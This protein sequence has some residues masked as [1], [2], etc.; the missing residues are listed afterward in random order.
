MWNAQ[1]IGPENDPK[2]EFGA[3]LLRCRFDGGSKPVRIRVSADQ[4]YKL[5]LNGVQIGFGPQRG[6]LDHWFYETYNLAARPGENVLE[7]VVWSFGRLAPMAQHFA[8][9]GF[10]CEALDPDHRTL[11]TPGGWEIAR[12]EEIGFAMMHAGVGEFYI[13]VGPGEIHGPESERVWRKPHGIS[14]AV[15]RGALTG[16]TPWMLVPRTL[17][18]MRYERRAKPPVR[19]RGFEGDAPSTADRAPFQPVDLAEPVVLDFEELLCAYPRVRLTGHGTVTL[20]YDEALWAPGGGKGNRDDVA[21]KRAK[22]YQ[23]VV[24]VDRSIEFEPLWWRTFRFVHLRAEGNVRLEAFDAYETGFPLEPKSKFEGDDDW[25]RPIWDVAVRTAQRCAGETYFDCP[26]YEQ[27]QYV[28]DTRIQALIGYYLTPDRVLQR[29]AIETLSWSLRDNG[30]TQS[31]YPSRQTQIIPPFSLWWILMLYDQMLYDRAPYRHDHEELAHG[32]IREWRVL[33]RGDQSRT[34]WNFAD[35]VD[36]W[37][38]GVPPGGAT[39]TIHLLTKL[40]ARIALADLLVHQPFATATVH[41]DELTSN[42][43]EIAEIHRH[44][45]DSQ[46]APTEHAEALYRV[47]QQMVGLE[48]DPWPAKALEDAKAARC[49]TYFQYYRHLAMRPKDYMAELGM[50]KTMIEDGLTTFAETPEPTRSDCHAWSAHPILGF[51]QLVAGVTSIAEGWRRARIE[52]RPGSLRRFDARIA[53]FDGELRVAF[54]DGKLIIDTPIPAELRWQS[55]ATL[56]APG[57]HR[58]G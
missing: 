37:P 18:P 43:L 47:C 8:R 34:Y 57:S 26:Y 32:I 21:G 40:M 45:R 2:S 28:G 56:L 41:A 39:S 17:P 44:Q 25:I 29:N 52:P 33:T 53:H 6:D 9:T 16:G 3:F 30:L 42:I 35:W 49:T 11:S 22:G 13:D 15:E 4:R 38:M 58:F 12:M 55:K 5:F 36:G 27:L 31:R 1:W 10:V 23:D 48:P 20:T 46:Q 54:E 51:F 14:G 50:W 7:A 19:R 24:N